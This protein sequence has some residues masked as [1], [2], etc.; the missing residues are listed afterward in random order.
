M[1]LVFPFKNII[2]NKLWEFYDKELVKDFSDSKFGTDSW[3]E[4]HINDKIE[5][6][7]DLLPSFE[8]EI[9]QT[10]NTT[11]QKTIDNYFSTL[12]ADLK[13]LKDCTNREYFIDKITEWNSETY[14]RYSETVEKESEEYAKQE[15]R[16]KNI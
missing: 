7:K 1:E 2:I 13:Y 11:D 5:I 6:W 9:L 14:K 10:I 8:N 3:K 15:N 4:E 12:A 16:K